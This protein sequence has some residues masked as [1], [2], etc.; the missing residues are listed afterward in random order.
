MYLLRK[1]TWSSHKCSDVF[2]ANEP[3]AH[4]LNAKTPHGFESLR[5]YQQK[6]PLGRLLL[7]GAEG[8]EPSSLAAVD[9][10]STAYA[11]SATLPLKVA[12][13]P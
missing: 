1:S 5:S 13:A 10:K 11:N 6:T 9:F 3:L 4:L 2:A 7:V 8:L 12:G